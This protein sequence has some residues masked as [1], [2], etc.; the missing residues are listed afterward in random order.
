MSNKV[1]VGNLP[2][3][4]TKEEIVEFFADCGAIERVHIATDR[5]TNRSK[6]YG[7]VTFDTTDAANKAVKLNGTEMSGRALRVDL[8]RENDTSGSGGGGYSGGRSGGGDYR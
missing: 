2:Y 8:A 4:V 6:G 1:Y 7:F 5:Q 3:R